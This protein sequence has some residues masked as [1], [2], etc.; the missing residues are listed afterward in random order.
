MRER[1]KEKERGRSEG[2]ERGTGAREER[3][4]GIRERNEGENEGGT[5]KI[6]M[7]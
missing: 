2:E 7:S 6:D 1:S 5:R 4:R 3:G